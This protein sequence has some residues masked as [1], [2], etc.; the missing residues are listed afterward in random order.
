VDI[1][2]IAVEDR[3]DRIV[4]LTVGKRWRV[5]RAFIGQGVGWLVGIA[6]AVLTAYLMFGGGQGLGLPSGR[7][8]VILLIALAVGPPLIAGAIAGGPPS[9]SSM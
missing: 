4:R 5:D 2:R 7:Y 6:V 8:P 9:A 1:D 3:N